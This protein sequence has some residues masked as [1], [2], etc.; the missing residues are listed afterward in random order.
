MLVLGWHGGVRSGEADDQA[1]GYS[2]HD[3]AAVLVRNGEIVAAIEEERLNRVKHSNFFPARSI[4]FCLERAGVTLKDVD[5]ITLDAQESVVDEFVTFCALVGPEEPL[6]T[7]REMIGRVF[8]R[9]FGV[10]VRSK[11]RFCKHHVAHIYSA[12]YASGQERGLA[13]ALDGEGDQRSGMVATFAGAT[14]T[15]LREYSPAQSLGTFYTSAIALLG[16][17]RFDEYKVMGLAPYGNADRHRALFDQFYALLPDGQFE[18]V[19]DGLKLALI[20]QHGLLPHIRRKGQPFTEVHKDL[21]ASIQDTLERIAMHVF[22]HQ[23]RATGERRL[24]YA[25]G[26]A[27]NCTLNGKLLYSGLFDEVFVQP[28]AH[29][30]GNALGAALASGAEEGMAPRSRKIQHLYLGTDIG[31]DRQIADRLDAWAAL[32]TRERHDDIAECAADLLAGGAVI[33]WVQGRSEFGPRALGNRSILADARPAEFKRVINAMV[34]KREGYRPFA[35]SVVEERLRDF[36][37]VPA[38]C[39]SLPFMTFVVRVRDEMRDVLGAVTHVDGTSRVQTVSRDT[40]PRYHAL[41]EAF[42]RRTGVPVLLN[43]SF[44][45]DAEPIVDSVDEA[46]VCFLTTGIQYL[47]VGDYLVTKAA[48]VDPRAVR[49][50]VPELRPY[51]KLVRRRRAASQAGGAY[52]HTIE[53]TASSFFVQPRTA[54]SDDAFTVLLGADDASSIEARCRATGITGEDRLAALTRELVELWGRRAI[55][56]QPA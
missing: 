42:G 19:P 33:G 5:L 31:T 38:S 14:I 6:I 21:A 23:A 26:V 46:V 28:A 49:R 53:S 40:N 1:V 56:L 41:I 17:R 22:E 51:Q 4:R 35:P 9:E 24:C 32:V 11:L 44:N 12:I 34:K 48:E 52:E 36:F 39:T 54:I 47:V 3:G 10:D 7:G 20:A 25:G 55:V 37:E 15:P 16:Y 30:A 50:F 27:H 13:V 45:N 8:E 29:D 2:T 18:I 43:T